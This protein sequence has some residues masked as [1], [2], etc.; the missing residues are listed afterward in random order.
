MKI[1][2]PN[3][4]TELL[5][6][7]HLV[8]HV[9]LL[10]TD[11]GLVLVDS[12][13][14][15]H[16]HHDPAGRLGPSRYFTR[17][18]L[19]LHETALHQVHD[20]G[21][22]RDDVRHII[23]THLDSDHIG[24]LSDFPAATVHV[25]AAEALGGFHAPTRRERLRFRPTQWAHRPTVIEHSPGGEPWRGFAAARPLTEIAP[26]IVLVPMPGHTRGH[27]AV[28]VDVGDRWI[29]H[30]GDAFYH[31]G[32]LTGTSKGPMALRAME[33]LIAFDR[34]QVRANHERLAELY[35]RRD[36]DLL[37][38]CSHDPEM[39]ALARSLS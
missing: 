24:G 21:F 32:T 16:D 22:D 12:G 20:L 27:T 18:P 23:L 36:P 30:C 33:T 2:H 7:A 39:L 1:H 11:A 34:R 4:G 35:A 8:S 25:S 17:P 31:P 15:T 3:C 13:F 6:G 5:P 38:V 9:M 14:G 26:G 29:L 19:H 37:I 28:A 10:E